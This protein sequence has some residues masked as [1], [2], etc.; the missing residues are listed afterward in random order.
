MLLGQAVMTRWYP[1]SSAWTSASPAW[2]KGLLNLDLYNNTYCWRMLL[3]LHYFKTCENT[4]V[5]KQ[6]LTWLM[7]SLCSG[8]QCGAS[9]V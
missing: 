7:V 8:L 1:N 9:P 3:N 2:M 5:T 6:L 4:K